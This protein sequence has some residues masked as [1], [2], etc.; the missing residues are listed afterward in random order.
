MKPGNLVGRGETHAAD[1]DL[2]DQS[3]PLPRGGHR[4]RLPA[5][6]PGVRR[7]EPAQ[8]PTASGI[9]LTLADGSTYAHTGPR[10]PGRSRGRSDDGHPGHPAGVSQ[11]GPAAAAR[12]DAAA[13]GCCSKPGRA[14]CWCRSGPSR[15]CRASDQRG[16][17]GR[18]QQGRVPHREG[19]PARRFALGDRGRR[20]SRASTSWSKGCSGFRTA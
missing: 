19:R 14:R 20:S 3:D 7:R 5:L 17:G 6:F 16:R 12:P 4:G 11:P 1:H 10:Q 9:Q 2:A 13:P 18:E 15:N 8:A